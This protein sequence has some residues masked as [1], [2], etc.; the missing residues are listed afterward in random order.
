MVRHASP[1]EPEDAERARSEKVVDFHNYSQALP[2]A[3][4][5]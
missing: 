3:I 2:N 5:A 1:T 4:E